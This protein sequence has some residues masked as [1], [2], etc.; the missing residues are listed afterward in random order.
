MSSLS[1]F[2]QELIKNRYKNAS[3]TLQSELERIFDNA[4][5]TGIL[6]LSADET[7]NNIALAASK[8]D[9]IKHLI[10]P[11]L[12]AYPD[13]KTLKFG[14]N[15]YFDFKLDKP[16]TQLATCPGL[17]ELILANTPLPEDTCTNMIKAFSKSTTLETLDLSGVNLNKYTY[18]DEE[19]KLLAQCTSL[20]KL[21]LANT[22]LSEESAKKIIA[23]FAENTTLKSLD[24]SDNQFSPEFI[25]EAVEPCKA[26]RIKLMKDRLLVMFGQKDKNSI[27]SKLPKEIAKEI[28][29]EMEHTSRNKFNN[30]KGKGTGS[31]I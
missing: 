23:A 9:F 20:T 24:F 17:K 3:K 19:F 7:Y 15:P 26:D 11:F 2:V 25:K 4:I 12:K 6:D 13:V 16:F 31:G 14:D 5:K 1:E 30:P 21:I 22:S 8:G 10:V 29:K 27:L 28:A 18:V